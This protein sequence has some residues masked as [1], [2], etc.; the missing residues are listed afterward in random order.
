MISFIHQFSLSGI[1]LF[2]FITGT[3]TKMYPPLLPIYKWQQSPSPLGKSPQWVL[4]SFDSIIILSFVSSI[5]SVLFFDILYFY[6]QVWITT[7]CTI[8]QKTSRRGFDDRGHGIL[9]YSQDVMAV[10]NGVSGQQRTP[11]YNY[12]IF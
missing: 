5:Y 7:R 10:Q 11:L 6:L 1:L 8:K 4:T 3:P 12:C 2:V 9:T